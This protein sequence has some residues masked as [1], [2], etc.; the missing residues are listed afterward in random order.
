MLNVITRAL[1]YTHRLLARNPLREDTVRR[2]TALQYET[3]DRAGALREYEQF[4]RRLRQELAVA[5]PMPEA[6]ALYE[7]IVRNTRLATETQT[8]QVADAA[9]LTT[10]IALPF[11]G[12]E[13]E[14]EKLYAASSRAA[15]HHGSL[16][17]VGGKSDVSKTRLVSELA[18]VVETQ[19]GRVLLECAPAALTPYQAIIEALR[20]GLPLIATLEIEPL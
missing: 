8:R 10:R 9:S 2:L 15:R 14:I 7:S 11:V 18:L 13:N 3:G 4:V 1:E 20:S 17:L 12:C 19:G 6:M 5:P 16:V